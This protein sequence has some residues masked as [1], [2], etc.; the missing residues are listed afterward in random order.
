MAVAR[1][2]FPAVAGALLFAAQVG[3]QDATG[4]VSGRV[5]DSTSQQPIP[6]VNVFVEGTPR[7]TLTR[8]DGSYIISEVPAG[9]Q[10]VRARQLGFASLTQDVTI[11]AGGTATANFAMVPQ[12]AALGEIVV[13]GYGTQRREAIT[14]S[15]ATIDATAANT[16]VIPNVNALIQGRVAGVQITQNSGEPG[17]G[18]QVRIR[19]G[20][21]I[22]ASNEPLYVIDGVAIDN[23]PAEVGAIDI[24]GNVQGAALSRSPLNL[25]N[26]SDIESITILKDASATAI[27]GARAANGVVLIETKKGMTSGTSLEYDSYV[28]SSSPAKYL[29]LLNG[30]EYRAFVQSQVAAGTM[31]PAQ[32]AAQ[33]TANT[34]WERAL[35]RTANT[36]NHNLAFTGGSPATRY[37]ASLN[38]MNQQGVVISDA[39]E[40][41]QG[42]L[43]ATHRA[44]DDKLRLG[45]NL[46]ASH[47]KND[48]IPH[49]NTGGFEGGVF[50][51]MVNFNP[52]RPVTVTDPVTGAVTFFEIGAGS[53]S[54]RN[55]VALAEQVDDFART[56]R[57]LGN[58]TSAYD[59]LSNLTA[60]LN[61]GVDRSESTR[62][63]YFPASNPIGAQWTG[64]ARQAQRDNQ[65]LTLQTLL[66]FND[67]ILD[68]HEVEVVG[69][70]EF[71]E[72]SN[73]EFHAEARNFLTDAFSFNNL[74]GGATLVRPSSNREDSRLVSFF[75]RGNYGFKD[76]YFL[77]GVLRYD[78]SSRFGEGNKWAL[79]P[80]VSA[81]WRV[82]SEEFMRGGM[83]SDLRLRAGWGLQGNPAVPVYAS[84][85]LLE[86]SA[87]YPFGDVPVTGVAPVRNPNPNLKW[88]ETEQVNVAV[89]FGLRNDQYKGTLEYYVKNT[90]DLLQ[91]VDVPQPASVSRRL[92]NVG[93][94]RNTGIEMSFDGVVVNRPN[95]NWSAG[96][97]FAA[98]RNRV[99]DLGP[100]TFIST[101]YVSGQGQS[102]Q[103][104]QRIMPGHA[105]G[106]FWGPVFT[107]ISDQL[108]ISGSDTLMKVGQQLFSCSSARLRCHNGQ[109]AF[110]VGEDFTVIGDANP[111]FTLSLNSRADWGRFDMSVLVR[112]EQGFDV[113]NNT[114]LV[115]RTKS[116]ART[117][118]N[119]LKAA[120]T[121]ADSIGEPSIFSSRWIENG[122]FVRLQ[123]VTIGYTLPAR[124]VGQARS[125]RIYLSGDNVLL[126]TGYT[127]YDPEVHTAAGRVEL[128]TVEPTRGIDYI[129]YPR[130]RTFTAGVRLAF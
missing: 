45:L 40:R 119:F 70:Y 16:G 108:V 54:V 32:L 121:D 83:L 91:V 76:K 41:Y 113:L 114:A 102:G 13:T 115:Y 62:R 37:R 65:S 26:P 98:E 25:L 21:S 23:A 47:V 59:L 53:Q 49:E 6:G 118:K 80:A 12:A 43:N 50:T 30:N 116:N 100:R 122:S 73:G 18:V 72:Y 15:I 99:V 124:F 56:T 109:T 111:D 82:S 69:G 89:D 60:Q 77:T 64:R 68:E 117:D 35:T 94:M 1:L 93:K 120:L 4:S 67:Q 33:G 11:T 17:A 107:G 34:D 106:T 81:S 39:F 66:T 2:L 20:T 57:T 27:Y 5:I 55:P 71:N 85:V 130:P 86:T 105:I 75:S 58:I 46:T 95:L 14:G 104:S 128:G 51:N 103:V 3:A 52:T 101:G 110:P 97:V 78:G 48:Y 88:E 31:T 63:T 19:G 92:E 9:A 22:S 28:A 42:R 36:T 112:S 129:T 90:R 24:S 38:Y 44:L 125:A 10:R 79:F 84:L 87:R 7:R 61:V 74:G 127:G 96:L 29:E 8:A 123:N 126:L